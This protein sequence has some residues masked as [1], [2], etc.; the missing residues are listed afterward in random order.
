MSS[1]DDPCE[2][3]RQGFPVNAVPLGNPPG[4]GGEGWSMNNTDGQGLYIKLKVE[5]GC[6]WVLS[7]HRSIHFRDEGTT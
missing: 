4:S 2:I 7:F 6:V 5:G 1:A 3:A